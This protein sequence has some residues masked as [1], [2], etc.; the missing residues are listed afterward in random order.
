M[1]Y[2]SGHV[3][4]FYG[5]LFLFSGI[6]Q[7]IRKD[8]ATEEFFPYWTVSITTQ[9]NQFAVGDI[10]EIFS[11]TDWIFSLF[12]GHDGTAINIRSTQVREFR[13]CQSIYISRVPEIQPVGLLF[14]KWREHC[15]AI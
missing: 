6:F 14:S 3:P 8:K 1:F 5:S 4:F 10:S 12:R 2:W 9:I 7:S 11:S 15:S 13:N